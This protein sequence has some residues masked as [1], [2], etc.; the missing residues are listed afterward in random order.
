MTPLE[1]IAE[2]EKGC[3][4]GGPVFDR[5]EGN[6]AGTTSPVQCQECTVALIEALKG[7]LGSIGNLHVGGPV[8]GDAP[9]ILSETTHYCFPSADGGDWVVREFGGQHFRS[10][11]NSV[12][13]RFKNGEQS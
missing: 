7:A 13:V 4:C 2:W 5:C 9:D 11:P 10:V 8:S 3:T 6:P 12:T 1:M